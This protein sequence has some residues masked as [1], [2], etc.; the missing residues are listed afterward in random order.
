[1]RPLVAVESLHRCA[2]LGGLPAGGLF[3]DHLPR[4]PAFGPLPLDLGPCRRG[5][6]L[7]AGRGSQRFLPVLGDHRRGFAVA[8]RKHRSAVACTTAPREAGS[9]AARGEDGT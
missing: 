8:N 3:G 9:W 7:I 6:A 1:G 2:T 5:A 4:V